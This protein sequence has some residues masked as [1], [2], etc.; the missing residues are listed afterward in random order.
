[1]PKLTFLEYVKARQIADNA[2]GDFVAEARADRR[3]PD[4]KSWDH[5]HTYLVTRGA[6]PDAI[7]AAKVVWRGYQAKLRR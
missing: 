3:I 7:K 5:L 6:I 1:M 4:A 2:A